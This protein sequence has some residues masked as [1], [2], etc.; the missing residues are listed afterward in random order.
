MSGLPPN[1]EWDYDGKRWFYRYKPNGHVQFHFPKEGDEF[2]DYFDA[3]SPIPDLAPEEKLES[4]QQ[5]KR[6]TTLDPDPKSKMRATG[7]PLADF[8]MNRSGF[9]GPGIDDDDGEDFYYQPE[10]LMYLGPGAYTDVS[11]LADEDERDEIPKDRRKSKGNGVQDENKD[12]TLLDATADRTGVSPLQSESNTPSVANSLPVREAAVVPEAVA[13][14]LPTEPVLT[15]STQD[16]PQTNQDASSPGV[17][18]LDSVEKPRVELPPLTGPPHAVHSPPWDP[19]GI[20]AEMAT[21]HTA[22][23]HIEIHP[24]PVEMGDNAVLAP[25]ETQIVDIGIAELPERT[26]PS[27]TSPP[28]PSTHEL[29]HQT[30]MTD[31]ALYGATFG[32]GSRPQSSSP[33]KSAQHT[34]E[35]KAGPFPPKPVPNDSLPDSRAP[36]AQ[37]SSEVSTNETFAIRRK[38]SNAGEKQG[39]Y[40]PYVPGAVPTVASEKLKRDPDSSRREHRN[41]LAREASLMMGTRQNYETSNMPSILQPPVVPPKHPLES[42][43]PPVQQPNNSTRPDIPRTQTEP[44]ILPSGAANAA[45]QPTH[46]PLQHIPSVLK[47]AS[48][49]PQGRPQPPLSSDSSHTQGKDV[50]A[51]LAAPTKTHFQNG[52]LNQTPPRKGQYLAFQ[53]GLAAKQVQQPRGTQLDATAPSGSIPHS[54]TPAPGQ[55]LMGPRPAIQRVET[56][57]TQSLSEQRQPAS[58]TSSQTATYKTSP[59]APG[60]PHFLQRPQAQGD[61]GQQPGSLTQLESPPATI[62]PRSSSDA[63]PHLSG[64]QGPAALIPGQPRVVASTEDNAAV[65]VGSSV[66]SRMAARPRSAMDFMQGRSPSGADQEIQQP[67]PSLPPDRSLPR[68]TSF[69]SSEVSSLG[70]PTGSQS[71]GQPL[72]TPSPLEVGGRRPSSGFFQGANVNGFPSAS[73]GGNSHVHLNNPGSR[74]ASFSGPTPTSPPA[75]IQPMASRQPADLSDVQSPPAIPKKVPIGPP[76]NNSQPP[77][78]MMPGNRTIQNLVGASQSPTNRR[79]SLP[80]GQLNDPAAQPVFE[81]S[82]FQQHGSVY[83][84]SQHQK[85]AYQLGYGISRPHSAQ[86]IQSQSSAG[87]QHAPQSIH[88]LQPGPKATK[89]ASERPQRPTV[90]PPSQQF[91]GPMSP[92]TPGHLLQ[93]IQEHGDNDHPTSSVP[94]RVASQTTKDPHRHSPSSARRSSTGSS[95]YPSSA[96]S[97]NGKGIEHLATQGLVH[98]PNRPPQQ[99]QQ[100]FSPALAIAGQTYSPIQTNPFQSPINSV[101]SPQHAMNPGSAFPVMQQPAKEKEKGSWLSK[102]MKGAGKPTMLQKPPPPNQT[103]SVLPH[104]PNN[105]APGQSGQWHNSPVNAMRPATIAPQQAN[106]ANTNPPTPA[107]F[108]QS[109]PP[110]PDLT[111]PGSQSL[112]N[113]PDHGHNLSRQS[114]DVPQARQ[115][116]APVVSIPQDTLKLQIHPQSIPFSSSAQPRNSPQQV[117]DR[118]SF[119]TQQRGP[120]ATSGLQEAP[121]Q[122]SQPQNMPSNPVHSFPPQPTDHQVS[123]TAPQ[124]KAFSSALQEA[125]KQHVTPL[126]MPVGPGPSLSQQPS[127]Q[128]PQITHQQKQ[129][130][131]P[132]PVASEPQ[133]PKLPDSGKFITQQTADLPPGGLAP[134]LGMPN[135]HQAIDNMSDAASVSAISVST[136]DVS[137]AQAQPVLKPQLVTVEKPNNST[138]QHQLP[139]RV[140]TTQSSGVQATPVAPPQEVKASH[141]MDQELTVAPLF[142]KRQTTA[143]VAPVPANTAPKVNDKWAKKPAVDYS[144]DDWGDDPWD[145]Q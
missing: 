26:S 73:E 120:P 77:L 54:L 2:P 49:F 130:V 22:P 144:G 133:I 64:V 66:V 79:H 100:P 93:P 23:A 55:Q 70:P 47:P 61:V 36:Q 101:Q 45:G 39:K 18:L 81:Q 24:D 58:H 86:P 107:M 143:T 84:S 44:T 134:A 121:K 63:P 9:G 89:Q 76:G 17:P 8:G 48:G 38:P 106:Q 85:E 110:V 94:V 32:S 4:Q 11:P 145:Y 105:V 92:R 67:G 57:P 41:S 102:F 72:Q 123:Q 131:L 69:A 98:Q 56:A 74:P 137:E 136:V 140:A 115:Q 28:V 3:L 20:M 139:S 113:G 118:Q 95:Q 1:W 83:P 127:R 21:E 71:S 29:L 78:S 111:S 124:Q 114:N 42:A 65:A 19:V 33:T 5:V 52:G 88:P 6:R 80:T 104:S 7:G 53:P 135:D 129:I 141:S 82:Q 125:P 43:Q 99:L 68:Q 51:P 25:I 59:G 75:P 50:V 91:F 16:L 34:P 142:S 108:H 13:K 35:S 60:L 90:T 10:N 96:E 103:F 37:K 117:N 97:P 112:Q 122:Y 31:Q 46:G 15:V 132:P 138:G 30:N 128:V 40:Q 126:S 87:S 27:D 62:R 14:E 12:K 116:Q 119:Q 109:R